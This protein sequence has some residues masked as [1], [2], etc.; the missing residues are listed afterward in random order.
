M[1][2]RLM[3]ASGVKL[4]ITTR[5]AHRTTLPASSTWPQV[6]QANLKQIGINVQIEGTP[7]SVNGGYISNYKSHTPMGIEP[8]SLDF[9]DAEA[10]INT[11]MDPSTPNAGPN[12]TRFGDPAFI[13][14]FNAAAAA[15]GATRA[16]LY[17]ALDKKLMTSVR[18]T[19]R[20]STRAG[21]TSSPPASA[22]TL[23]R[24]DGR[25]QLQHAVC[26]VTSVHQRARR[27]GDLNRQHQG[28]AAHPGRGP[29][30]AAVR[31]ARPGPRWPR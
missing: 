12:L 18:P 29:S 13:P 6:I 30:L 3:K 20:S 4:P 27:P 10:I 24:R 9:P 28:R 25:D 8:W 31:A 11:G 23:Q 14:L 5:C 19:R 1:A 22:V 16:Q 7:N 2:K 15:P 17:A 21:T 26:Q